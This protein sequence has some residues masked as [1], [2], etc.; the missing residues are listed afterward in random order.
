M[1]DDGP[2]MSPE[3]ASKIFAPFFTTKQAGHGTGLGLAQAREFANN[4]GGDVR[5]DTA[6][7]AGTTMNLYLRVLGRISVADQ[8]G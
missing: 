4:T 8:A 6:P 5:V 2:G 1:K 3:L 7:G